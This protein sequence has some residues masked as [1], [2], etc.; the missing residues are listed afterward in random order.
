MARPASQFL[1]VLMPAPGTIEPRLPRIST[2]GRFLHKKATITATIRQDKGVR[3]L[4]VKDIKPPVA[5]SGKN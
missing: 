1:L 2:F 3:S 4:E 5:T